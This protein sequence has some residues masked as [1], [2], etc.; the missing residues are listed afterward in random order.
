MARLF[1]YRPRGEAIRSFHTL[2]VRH[3]AI[4]GHIPTD[5]ALKT[6]TGGRVDRWMQAYEDFV[7]LTE[8]KQAQNN[9][10]QAEKKFLATQ[11]ERRQQQQTLETIQSRLRAVSAELEKT[12]RADERYLDLVRNE[13][14]IIREEN[15]VVSN[16]RN[17]EK[18][19]RESFAVLSSALRDSHE[20]ERA[21]A[22]KTKYWSIIGSIVGAIIGITGTT[23]NN[24]LKMKELRG[25]VT[26]AGQ[27]SEDLRNLSVELCKTVSVQ[28]QKMD[29]LL[30]D[31]HA[32]AAD[33]NNPRAAVTL[34]RIKFSPTASDLQQQTEKI[35]LA[36][37]SQE[38]N[39]DSEIRE[40]R[41]LL[42]IEKSQMMK[43]D[44]NVVYVGPEV[45]SMMRRTE[46]NLERKIKY[47]A[48]ATATFVYGALALTLPI[49][50]SFFRGNS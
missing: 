37:K 14:S 29:S 39:L 47:S 15:D 28:S 20:K 9:V 44:D 22:E 2:S 16:I 19:E 30:V 42:G 1:L 41:R 33:G 7:G 12:N 24:Y 11:E 36:L 50:F 10:L 5:M 35:L 18:A 31:L 38:E 49:V 6:V 21:R 4:T 8:V 13:H 48:L 45:E 46:E 3:R 43:G 32:S 17:L 27:N 26:S 23:I 40:I 34:E 25:I